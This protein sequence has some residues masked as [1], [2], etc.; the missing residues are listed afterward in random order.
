MSAQVW[1]PPNSG[2]DAKDL[3]L[4]N[5][6]MS[7]M[8][9]RLTIDGTALGLRLS[10]IA[11]PRLTG[12]L[13]IINVAGGGT[14]YVH[15]DAFPFQ[16][17]LGVDL[18]L[19]A[20][21]HIPA[22]L[23]DAIYAGSLELL[24]Q[25]LPDTLTG[26]MQHDALRSGPPP[27]GTDIKWFA[28]ALDGFAEEPVFFSFGSAAKDICAHLNDTLAQPRSVLAALREEL[29]AVTHR[30]I[31]QATLCADDARH[32]GI[33]DFIVS[34]DQ[35]AATSLLIRCE[36]H[37]YHFE[38]TDEGWR[39]TDISPPDHATRISDMDETPDA[40]AVQTAMAPKSET[41]SLQDAAA[42]VS[43]VLTFECGSARISL[44][45]LETY[46]IGA[47][48]PLPDQLTQDGLQVTIRCG[49]RAIA[50]GDVVQVDDRLAIRISQ[51]LAQQT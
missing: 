26:R 39:C 10:P 14:L 8:G 19:Q 34:A 11:K 24:L 5:A 22:E 33:G 40:S 23:K 47:V 35:A 49:E 15:I 16:N 13:H 3:P 20:A 29:D 27:E 50:R 18:D 51:I 4:W 32:L 44:A 41:D 38:P 36:G 2:V 17:L 12:P 30:V 25:N 46:Q 43:T 31:G 48:V 37:N 21:D 45:E 9:T 6:A 1:L 7:H 28:A 42:N